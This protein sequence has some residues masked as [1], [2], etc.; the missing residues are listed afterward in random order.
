MNEGNLGNI[1]KTYE[2]FIDRFPFGSIYMEK[3]LILKNQ[4]DTINDIKYVYKSNSLLEVNKNISVGTIHIKFKS[5]S[6]NITN[7]EYYLSFPFENTDYDG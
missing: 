2:D 4:F 7:V 5:I 1:E 3:N 6:S